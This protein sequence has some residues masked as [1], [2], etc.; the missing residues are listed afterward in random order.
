[1]NDFVE[2]ILKVNT[3]SLKDE[4]YFKAAYFEFERLMKIS[5]SSPV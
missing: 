4:E 3:I 1:M 5:K 2:L